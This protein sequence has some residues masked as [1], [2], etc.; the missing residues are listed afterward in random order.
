MRR[1]H[2][3][4][5]PIIIV[6]VVLVLVLAVV[7]FIFATNV[8]V[9]GH[10]YPKKAEFLNLRG[11]EV[12][13]E[14]FEQIREKLPRCDIYWDVPLSSGSQPENLQILKLDK[15]TDEDVKAIGYFDD[16]M[17]VEAETCTDYAQLQKLR[18]TYPDL[19]VI[20]N[21]IIGGN[22]YPYDATEV[23]LTSL[24]DEDIALVQYLPNLKSIQAGQCDDYAK[25]EQLKAA[26]PELTVSTTVT[27]A[28]QEY[29]GETTEM[30]VTG[31]TE[32]DAVYLKYLPKLKSLH[33]VDPAVDIQKIQAMQSELPD[34]A[35]TW[36]VTISGKTLRCDATEVEIADVQVD[37][38]QLKNALSY[39]PDLEMVFLNQCTVDNDAMAALRDEV[40]A[41][42]KLVWTVQCGSITVRTDA[43][44]FHPIQQYVWYFF[45]ED[46]ANLVYCED[47]ICVD[48]G[49]MSI[50]H[51]QW[52]KGMPKLKYLILA[53]T[54]V[55]DLSG[56]ENCKELVFLEVDW[57]IVKDF[58]PL[59]QCTA[60][61]DL[62]IGNTYA[63]V[64]PLTQMTWLKHLWCVGRGEAAAS[65]LNEALAEHGTMI[66]F[67]AEHT[68]GGIWR[69]LPNYYA[70]RDV[71]GM[72]YMA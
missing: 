44:Y 23:V 12:T 9:N 50:H 45:D 26:Y 67:R 58:T 2:T 70:M 39:L 57:S 17:L 21:V 34:A 3:N 63:D 47:M 18:E 60:L 36:E 66:F 16:L 53:H 41:D 30:T 54:Q 22:S 27:I 14:E 6:A 7:I 19:V 59:L 42:Y 24:T 32:E 37:A 35:I 40:R 56:I 1:K 5:L 29:D 43:T 25:V 55:S 69:Q 10:L 28:G 52:L 38:D 71:L 8:L 68:V 20:Y 49:H 13:V 31:L 61:E 4:P 65:V 33:L 48:L 11:K 64:T 15:L 46:A 51:V 62:N 72:P